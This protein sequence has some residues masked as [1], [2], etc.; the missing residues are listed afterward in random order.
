LSQQDVA[1]LS[2]LQMY[3]NGIFIQIQGALVAIAT[4]ATILSICRWFRVFR[5]NMDHKLVKVIQLLTVSVAMFQGQQT[6]I[7][8]K[9]ND[10]LLIYHT[11]R[12]FLPFH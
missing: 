5:G 1:L 6:S 8:S 12:V 2:H 9:M 4:L 10:I 3:S 7:L 11:D